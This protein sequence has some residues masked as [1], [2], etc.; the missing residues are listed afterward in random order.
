MTMTM[1]HAE[2]KTK[3]ELSTRKSPWIYKFSYYMLQQICIDKYEY[4]ITFD[5]RKDKDK[6]KMTKRP[7][8]CYIF[9]NDMI[10]GCQIWWW[11]INQWCITEGDASQ[12]MHRRWCTAGDAPQVMHRRWCTVGDAPQVMH[13]RKVFTFTLHK[14][15]WRNSHQ[16]AQKELVVVKTTHVWLG[17]GITVI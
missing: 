9:E 16:F 4:G 1:T 6:D 10:Q 5:S 7:K 12:M 3:T 8:M 2:T 17:K 15:S 14:S 11:W 13:R